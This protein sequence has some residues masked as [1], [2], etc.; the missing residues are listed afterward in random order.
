MESRAV[1]Y[2]TSDPLLASEYVTTQI[3]VSA[4]SQIS[5][6]AAAP[7]LPRD[8]GATAREMS[9]NKGWRPFTARERK[10]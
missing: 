7:A 5:E 4:G 3:L 8:P 1:S 6:S 9:A 10:V 2:V